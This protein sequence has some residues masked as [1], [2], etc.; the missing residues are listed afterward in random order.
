MAKAKS[1]REALGRV[2]SRLLVAEQLCSVVLHGQADFGPFE[3]SPIGDL[4]FVFDDTLR[5]IRRELDAAMR[6]SAS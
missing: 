1:M 4:A 5:S 6:E 3:G 2:E